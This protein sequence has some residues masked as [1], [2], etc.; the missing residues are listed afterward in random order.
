MKFS[1]F[2]LI[3]AILIPECI[4]V[5]GAFFTFS[6]ILNWYVNVAKPG[7]TPPS[8]VFAPVWTVLFALMGIALYLVWSKAGRFKK[9]A[10]VLFS[11]QL[12]LNLLWT[13]IFFEFHNIKLAFFEIIFLWIFILGTIFLFS[14]I[15]KAAAW[16]LVPYI[17]WV[18]F[19][20][21]LNYS[22]WRVNAYY[23]PCTQE[24]KLCSD[25]SYVGRTGP[26]CEFA[27]CPDGNEVGWQTFTD[28]KLGVSFKY[29]EFLTAN[30]IHT[31]DWPPQVQV[32]NKSFVCTEGGSEIAPAGITE[33]R[34]VDD[35]EYCV[36]KESQ[37]A[38]GSIYTQ[39]A[40][41]FPKD[42]KTVI[43]TFSLQFTQCGNYDEPNKSA[44]ENERTAFDI[45]GVVDRIAKTFAF[46]NETKGKIEGTVLLGPTCPVIKNPPE[47]QCADKPYKTNI[48]IIK[49]GSPQSSPFRVVSSDTLG[50]YEVM[51][52]VGEYALQPVGGNTLPRCET[53]DVIVEAN[54]IEEIN[55]FCDTGIR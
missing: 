25:G 5:L 7:F 32:L 38:A 55:L 36:T 8:W 49:I 15:S 33:K 31:V 23:E 43:L 1:F 6:N 16:L 48:Q 9:S 47:P 46:I 29:P 45:D 41:A 24:A 27:K 22:I 50:K 54:K 37:G 53:K 2:R 19:A 11:I 44:C 21:F 51:L 14:K 10:I 4:G 13:I 17:L 26:N 3:I 52:P 39:Y 12:G 18:S 34:M 40:Y 42:N 30:Y 20:G 35:R 28:N